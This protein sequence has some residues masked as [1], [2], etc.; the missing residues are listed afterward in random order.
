[1]K[2]YKFI[3]IILAVLFLSGCTV[4]S[5]VEV[6]YDGTV[7]EN[8]KVLVNNV[9]FKSD[10][11]SEKQLIESSISNYRTAL[12]YRNYTYE[13]EQGKE[14]SG[15]NATKNHDDI[16]S[17]FQD[18]IFNQ[19]VYKH[20]KC[21]EDDY[22]YTI[23]NDT[24]YIPYCSNCSDWPALDDVVFS[25]KLPILATENNADEVNDSTYVWKY[26]KYSP[27][28]KSFYLKISKSALKE[29][30]EKYNKEQKIKS[31]IKN[32]IM[33]VSIIVIFIILYLIAKK[34]Y[35]KNQENKLDY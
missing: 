3:I 8:V 10:K 2:K 20:V 11:Y 31:I 19:Y 29:Y 18:T 16:C 14:L 5:N 21:T 34:L 22:Y 12:D 17:Y 9:M 13:A 26:N 7:K 24:N 33:I 25:I 4:R 15:L 30:E 28:N 32:S 35:K 27:D 6:N 1:M 23:Q